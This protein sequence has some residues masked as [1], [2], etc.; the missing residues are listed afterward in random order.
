[1]KA[2]QEEILAKMRTNQEEIKAS[3]QKIK[4]MKGALVSRTDVHQARTEAIQEEMKAKMNIN[5]ERM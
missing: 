1:M 4:L 3:Q 2:G 5:Q